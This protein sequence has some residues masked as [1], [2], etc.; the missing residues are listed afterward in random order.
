MITIVGYSDEVLRKTTCPNCG[1]ILQYAKSDI[2]EKYIKDYGGGGDMYYRINCP[3]CFN[4]L[5][6]PK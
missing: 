2:T 3:S 4:T 1:A 5:D 6:V